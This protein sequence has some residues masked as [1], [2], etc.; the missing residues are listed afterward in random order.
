MSSL[1]MVENARMREECFSIRGVELF[2]IVNKHGKMV[3]CWG[4]KD[5]NMSKNKKDMFLMQIALC[6]SMQCDFNEE[7]GTVN[8]CVIQREKTKFVSFPLSEG[9]VALAIIDKKTN[10]KTIVSRIKQMYRIHICNQ[11]PNE[12]RF[13]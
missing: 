1:E 4:K 7:F 10:Y 11:N 9:N 13:S 8:F 12:G 6:N 2:G 3:D 5:L